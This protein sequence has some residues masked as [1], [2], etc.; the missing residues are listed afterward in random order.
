M[1]TYKTTHGAR[2]TDYRSAEEVAELLQHAGEVLYAESVSAD[3]RE[4]ENCPRAKY[5]RRKSNMFLD[6]ARKIRIG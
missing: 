3:K 4:S 6:A 1:K 2:V 5:L